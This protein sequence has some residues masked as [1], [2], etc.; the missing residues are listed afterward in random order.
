MGPIGAV[1]S[2]ILLFRVAPISSYSHEYRPR[3]CAGGYLLHVR[4]DTN[5]EQAALREGMDSYMAVPVIS[6]T[7]YS[8]TIQ[9]FILD[10]CCSGFHQVLVIVFAE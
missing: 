7:R 2:H 4:S 6:S 10:G 1:L 9:L 8:K 5:A 3:P